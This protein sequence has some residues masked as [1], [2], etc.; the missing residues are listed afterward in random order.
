MVRTARCEW[1][2]CPR[3]WCLV[4]GTMPPLMATWPLQNHCASAP[5]TAR[6]D[7]ERGQ[8]MENG[9]WAMRSGKMEKLHC[10]RTGQEEE[11]CESHILGLC[12]TRRPD[13]LPGSGLLLLLTQT[14][15]AHTRPWCDLPLG[16]LCFLPSLDMPRRARKI[17]EQ[18][19]NVLKF[20]PS[21]WLRCSFR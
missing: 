3:A 2:Y 18:C 16:D 19:V 21:A 7:D 20:M 17:Y 13:L 8:T 4:L 11:G 5:W 9:N 14:T 6:K 15:H 10:R 1:R 12:D